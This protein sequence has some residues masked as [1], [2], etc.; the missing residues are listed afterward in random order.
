MLKT[1]SLADIDKKIRSEIFPP[2]YSPIPTIKNVFFVELKNYIEED[3]D[4]SE[5]VRIGKNGELEK[6]PK[7]KLAQLNRTKLNPGTIKAWHLH[8]KQDVLWYL[9]PVDYLFVGLWDIRKNSETVGLRMRVVLGEGKSQ[10]LFIPRGVAHGSANFTTR[11]VY[12]HYFT[13]RTFEVKN[14]DEKRI[15]WDISGA[16]FWTPVRE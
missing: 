3:G 13:N 14:P 2:D 9:N 16:D 6:V 10:L 11:P 1:L 12:L 7:F 15:R 8:L 5:I 4:F